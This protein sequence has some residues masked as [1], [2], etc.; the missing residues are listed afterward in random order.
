MNLSPLDIGMFAVYLAFLILGVLASPRTPLA[1]T[2]LVLS[3][4]CAIL[5]VV[6]RLQL[7]DAFSVGAEARR[8]VTHGLYAK[9]R[10]PIYLFGTSAFL[11]VVL[12]L[13]GLPALLIWLIIGLIQISR[14]RREE[15]LLEATFGAEYIAYRRQTWF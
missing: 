3:G 15:R 7:G 10:H 11:F 1:I 9:V 13:Q 14:V 4:V 2:S 8:L 12:A 5:W 6:A